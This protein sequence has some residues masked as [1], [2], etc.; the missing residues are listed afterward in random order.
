MM[1][2]SLSDVGQTLLETVKKPPSQNQFLPKRQSLNETP[3]MPC[4]FPEE[5]AQ[6]KIN[7]NSVHIGLSEQR[8][9]RQRRT[10]TRLPR[11]T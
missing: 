5:L 9:W 11:R 10:P 4:P 1:M 8:G 2:T 7:D 6:L 3:V